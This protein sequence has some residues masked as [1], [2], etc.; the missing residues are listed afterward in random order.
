MATTADGHA[1]ADSGVTALPATVLLLLQEP[2]LA[3]SFHFP[4][5][6]AVGV[7]HSVLAVPVLVPEVLQTA[8]LVAAERQHAL[9]SDCDLPIPSHLL[10]SA[11]I[12]H[13]L[14]VP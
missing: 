14:P 9:P 2:V 4:F 1:A 12:L 8:I 3:V 5:S 10:S 13:L 6:A 7:L 11:L